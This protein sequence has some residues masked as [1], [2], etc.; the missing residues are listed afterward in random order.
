MIP[1][2]DIANNLG[3]GIPNLK[4]YFILSWLEELGNSIEL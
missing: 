3:V 2:I 1:K 4:N